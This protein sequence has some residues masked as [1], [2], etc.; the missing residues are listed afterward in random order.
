MC[1]QLTECTLKLLEVALDPLLVLM[2]QHDRVILLS[3]ESLE[4]MVAC[5]KRLVVEVQLVILVLLV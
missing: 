2:H 4:I 5:L 3:Q 1:L